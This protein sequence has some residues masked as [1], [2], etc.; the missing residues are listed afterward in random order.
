MLGNFTAEAMRA[1]P[2]V[3]TEIAITNTL[4][5]R[6]DIGAEFGDDELWPI[7]LNDLFNAMPFDN[8][9]TTM[10]LS[11]S[12]VR[13]VLDYVSARS[14]ERGCNSQA[15]VAGLT[16]E[17]NCCTFTADNI[18]V[19]G[20][21]IDDNGTYE[22]ATNNYIAHGG[23]GFAMLER[24]TTQF[25]TGI[26]IRDVVREAMTQVYDLPDYDANIAVEDGRIIP[27]FDCAEE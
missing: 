23:S 27:V 11:G 12:E 26:S 22:V 16:F 17:M 4:G 15:Q 18:H 21:P 25:D 2:G 14:S 6:S 8:T 3:E 1:Y 5:T 9:I 20:V 24:N 19:N 13:E 7:T 10:F